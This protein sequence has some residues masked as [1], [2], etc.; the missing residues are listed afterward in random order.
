MRA[1]KSGPNETNSTG[2]F[3]AGRAII[4]SL[5]RGKLN[6]SVREFAAIAHRMGFAGGFAGRIIFSGS[7]EPNAARSA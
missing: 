7:C 1:G 3:A 6:Q 2:A 4:E 5:L